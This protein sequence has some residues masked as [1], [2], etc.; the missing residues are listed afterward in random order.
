MPA[1]ELIRNDIEAARFSRYVPDY[2]IALRSRAE[3]DWRSGKDTAAIA[4]YEE[5]ERVA[6]GYWPVRR[7]LA[8]LYLS[9]ARKVASVDR[10]A[11]TAEFNKAQEWIER[12][13]VRTR[14]MPTRE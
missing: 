11:A 12:S 2:L 13:S 10:R 6:P 5:V 8:T 9:R 14:T 3:W 4:D 7:L 1:E